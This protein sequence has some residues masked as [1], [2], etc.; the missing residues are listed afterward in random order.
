[1]NSEKLDNKENPKRNTHGSPERGNM[2]EFL[3]KLEVGR[4]GGQ[5]R[6]EGGKGKGGRE[7]MGTIG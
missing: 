6:R 4:K 5:K 7:H 3:R 2:Q 1:M